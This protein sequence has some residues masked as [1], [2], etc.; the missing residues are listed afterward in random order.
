MGDPGQCFPSRFQ[1]PL[2]KATELS[3][4]RADDGLPT[5][6]LLNQIRDWGIARLRP[7]NMLF[8]FFSALPCGIL[9]PNQLL[10][11]LPLHWKHGALTTGLPGKSTKKVHFK[12]SG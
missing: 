12:A 3:V 2:I 8:F 9:V 1:E 5:L 7:E 4:K 6:D 11:L 10:N